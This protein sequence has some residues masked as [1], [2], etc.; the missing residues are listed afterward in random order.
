KTTLAASTL[1]AASLLIA[2]GCSKEEK[3]SAHEAPAPTPAA[4]AKQ[5]VVNL[6]ADSP[7]LQQIT[8]KTV[9]ERE[10]PTDEV[11]APGKIEVNPN[12]VS[13]VV[14]PLG[15]RVTSVMVHLGDFVKQGEPLLLVESPDADQAMS[16]YLQAQASVSNAKS[17][18]LKTKADADR[19]HD[20]DAQ[21][22][23]AKKDVLNA[24]ASLQQSQAA[25]E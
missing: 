5:G 1:L 2:T 9:Q 20:L 4:D 3:T 22:A 17:I 16:T 11:I 24:D 10:V 23:V 25:V 12:R 8:V 15:G 18:M 13:H 14:L 19:L 7:K 6:P 21:N